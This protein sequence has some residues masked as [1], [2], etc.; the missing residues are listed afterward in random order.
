MC[1]R[2]IPFLSAPREDSRF[3]HRGRGGEN[4]NV[5]FKEVDQIWISLQANSLWSPEFPS[6][7]FRFQQKNQQLGSWIQA[8]FREQV[9]TGERQVYE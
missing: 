9:A 5:S 4:S 2:G 7:H 6:E 3:F 1:L 8:T